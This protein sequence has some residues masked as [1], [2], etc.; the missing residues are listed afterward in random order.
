VTHLST[1]FQAISASALFILLGSLIL[2]FPGVQNDEALFAIP[3][4]L[5]TAKDLS[6]IIFHRHIPLMVMSY[7]GTLKTWLYAG[8]FKFSSV[9]IWSV[10]LP[11]VLAGALTVFIFYRFTSRAAGPA[12]AVIAAFLLASDPCFLLTNTFD[13]GPVALGH[14]LLV[15]GCF[16]L[17]RFGQ[18]VHR[19]RDLALGFFFLGLGLWNKALM[20]WVLA[21]LACALVVV[22]H[23]EG[24]KL[25]SRKRIAIGIIAFILGALPVLLYNIRHPNS[26]LGSN[27]HIESASASVV[28][29][30][31]LM[32]LRVT[33]NGSGLFAFIPAPEWDRPRPPETRRGRAAQWVSD[34]LLKSQSSGFDYLFLA[35]LAA[36]P[37]WWRSR[38]ARFSLAF[39]IVTWIAMAATQG[40][41]G[42]VHHTILLWPFP[43]FFVAVVLA[44]LP[45]RRVAM[46]IG[47]VAVAMNL[48]VDNEYLRELDVNGASGGFTD[49]L[50][51]LSAAIPDG[52]PIYVVDWG[53]DN[54]IAMFHEG[55]A[56]VRPVDGLF[57]T[58]TPNEGER[59][60]IETVFSDPA[61]IF[62]GHVP[63]RETTPE[64]RPILDRAAAS[65]GRQ[66]Q[67]IRIITDSHGRPEFEIF[68][69]V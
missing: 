60:M 8:I 62:V 7:V 19:M 33:L 35:A 21:G 38:A 63:G 28:V 68:K 23:R 48:L 18:E 27:A 12:A 11:M 54:T 43:Q 65:F 44:A 46:A 34:H 29:K 25:A 26:T 61:A 66:K 51:P 15:T 17:V 59:H 39:M 3:I 47:I 14:L 58:S 4:Y 67:M 1:R 22:F 56:L 36:V 31:K 49:A 24:R 5:F 13:W 9:N 20:L 52:P 30:N 37:L 2:P 69:F 41:G 10:R 50:F 53:M 40:A 57:R 55:R 16:F 32:M 45:W 6:I 64:V 42:A